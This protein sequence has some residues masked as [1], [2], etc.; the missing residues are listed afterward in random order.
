MS[1][2]PISEHIDCGK[3]QETS[4]KYNQDFDEYEPNTVY[5]ANGIVDPIKAKNQQQEMVKN[6]KVN[7]KS[8]DHMRK[9][10]AISVNEI[11]NKVN[12]AGYNPEK[13][14]CGDMPEN[15]QINEYE[16]K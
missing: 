13:R 12:Q 7:M 11:M 10:K 3:L 1:N 15:T 5:I 4:F 2:Q 9:Q 14:Y 16:W 6:Y 8:V